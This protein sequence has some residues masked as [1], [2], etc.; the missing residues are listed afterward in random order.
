[1]IMITN[2]IF[3]KYFIT[4]PAVDCVL[5]LKLQFCRHVNWL[6]ISQILLDTAFQLFETVEKV[7]NGI[8]TAVVKLATDFTVGSDGSISTR[9]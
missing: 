9:A 2:T 4:Y 7:V 6:D 8:L 3:S 5:K 1:M